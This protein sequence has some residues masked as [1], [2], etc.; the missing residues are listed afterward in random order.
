MAFVSFTFCERIVDRDAFIT[1]S[2]I[3]RATSAIG[4]AAVKPRHCQFYWE[5]IQIML[6]W[7]QYVGFCLLNSNDIL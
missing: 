4:G 7:C 3:L 5:N 2:F 6:E 1:V